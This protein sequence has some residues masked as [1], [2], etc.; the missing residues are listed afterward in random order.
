MYKDTAHLPHEQERH[1]ATRIE[2]PTRG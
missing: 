2:D 1:L